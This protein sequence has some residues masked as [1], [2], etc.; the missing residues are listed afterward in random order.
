MA[1]TLLPVVIAP[2]GL[3]GTT[4]YSG[5]GLGIFTIYTATKP[6]DG[7]LA[8][9]VNYTRRIGCYVGGTEDLC[10][11][12]AARGDDYVEWRIFRDH[13]SSTTKELNVLCRRGGNTALAFYKLAMPAEPPDGLMDSDDPLYPQPLQ[14]YYGVRLACLGGDAAMLVS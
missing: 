13:K 9:P 10:A 6:Y 1:S 2:A 12:L 11:M 8:L 14:W 7:F 3:G 4:I 5:S